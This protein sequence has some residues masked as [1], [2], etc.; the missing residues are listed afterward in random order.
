MQT[1]ELMVVLNSSDEWK[2]EKK[3]KSL[4][5]NLFEDQKHTIDRVEYLGKK[6]LAYPIAKQTEGVYL[7][8]QLS[9]EALIV[10]QLQ[11]RTKLNENVLRY[12]LTVKENVS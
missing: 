8:A 10:G 12:L 2:D 4:L 1:Y 3:Q 9:S 6:P 5:A 7:L 11:K